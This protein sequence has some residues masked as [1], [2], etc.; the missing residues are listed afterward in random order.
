MTRCP[1]CN[2]LP[3]R[4]LCDRAG[5]DD[6]VSKHIGDHAANEWAKA[7]G[8]TL[9]SEADTARLKGG[10]LGDED[11]GGAQVQLA[12]IR[13]G[14]EWSARVGCYEEWLDARLQAIDIPALKAE[15]DRLK[16]WKDVLKLHRQGRTLLEIGAAHGHGKAWAVELFGKIM[17]AVEN[18]HALPGGVANAQAV[19]IFCAW[20]GKAIE[21]RGGRRGRPMRFCV[22]A[23]NDAF[24]NEVRAKKREMNAIKAGTRSRTGGRRPTAQNA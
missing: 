6:R 22:R 12:E 20:C 8:V 18:A 14:Q 1:T 5:S 16:R 24:H 11:R 19:P 21:P 7:R 17:V 23:H 15:R 10:H 9:P 2:R 3:A 4:C 13:A